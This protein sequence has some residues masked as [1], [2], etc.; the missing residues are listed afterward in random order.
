MQDRY[1]YADLCLAL[2]KFDLPHIG[3]VAVLPISAKDS[4]FVGART[5]Q[6][7]GDLRSLGGRF[8]AVFRLRCAL[9]RIAREQPAL[10]RIL[11][12]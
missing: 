8:R 11:N 2:V 1:I 3:E 9:S 5:G 4:D 10:I 12:L 7:T 6:W